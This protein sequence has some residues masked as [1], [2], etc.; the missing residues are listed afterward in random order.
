MEKSLMEI[1]INFEFFVKRLYI[2]PVE[3]TRVC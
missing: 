1:E 3:M 2:Y